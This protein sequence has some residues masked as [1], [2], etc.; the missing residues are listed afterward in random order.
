MARVQDSDPLASAAERR[1]FRF[2]LFGVALGTMLAPLNTT[3]VA[4]ALPDIGG[5]FDAG[6]DAV[7]WTITAYVI[8]MAVVQP[9]GG[10]V[11]DLYGRRRLFLF[12]MMGFGVASVLAALSVDL[13]MLL[14]TRV[15]QAL[16]AAMMLPTGAALVRQVFPIERRAAAFGVVGAAAGLAAGIGPVVGGGILALGGWRAM[17]WM[18]VP[19]VLLGLVV[20][21]RFF[22]PAAKRG[23]RPPFDLA[24]AV[25]LGGAMIAFAMALS[26]AGGV[27]LGL[28]AGL[29]G[30]AAALLVL[31]AVNEHRVVEPLTDP[32]LLGNRYFLGPTGT[33]LF[34]TIALYAI[35]LVAPLLLKVVQERGSAETGLIMAALSAPV[36]VFARVGG[37][38]ADRFG[39]RRPAMAGGVLQT[40]G[41]ALLLILDLDASAWPVV[42]G[43]LLMGMGLSL[44]IPAS[45]TA[46]VEAVEERDAGM[47]SGVYS[48]GR[49]IGS[50]VGAAALAALI[51]TVAVDDISSGDLTP[52]FVLITAAGAASIGSAWFIRPRRRGAIVGVPDPAA[53]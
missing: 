53:R 47:A 50:L 23:E 29:G 22:P 26:L 27:P 13:T 10:K 11:G 17:F 49:Y 21:Y 51:A 30:A 12:S 36:F 2:I 38:L 52:V 15:V 14:V 7:T 45:Q 34:S 41:A 18:N 19:V 20:A 46:A 24:G 43:L 28:T 32:R 40:A 16:T 31:F 6:L 42:A 9:I 3:L 37:R 48:M 25:L 5:E 8:A 1:T 35:I 4:L 39:R 44:Q 33:I